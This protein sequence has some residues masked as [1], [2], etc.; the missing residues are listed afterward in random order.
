M[1]EIQSLIS[2]LQEK[3]KKQTDDLV[4]REQEVG[5]LKNQIAN[6][7]D[8]LKRLVKNMDSACEGK[9]DERME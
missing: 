1:T 8:E 2:Q 5:C 6:D 4:K 7:R 9:S 3:V